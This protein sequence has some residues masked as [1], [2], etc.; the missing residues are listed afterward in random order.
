MERT[1]DIKERNP[2]CIQTPRCNYLKSTDTKLNSLRCW[3]VSNMFQHCQHVMYSDWGEIIPSYTQLT[4]GKHW[5]PYIHKYCQFKINFNL[6]KVGECLKYH[7][8]L[9]FNLALSYCGFV[10]SLAICPSC[11]HLFFTSCLCGFPPVLLYCLTCASSV[12]LVVVLSF[13]TIPAPFTLFLVPHTFTFS[14]DSWIFPSQWL[15]ALV[16]PVPRYPF[17]LMHVVLALGCWFL[18]LFTFKP[19][20]FMFPVF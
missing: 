3:L 13:S 7:K 4:M 2:F 18:V 14:V 9:Y 12:H 1:S 10:V 19:C 16:S 20:V 17:L 11:F 6:T 5:E 8:V 15:S